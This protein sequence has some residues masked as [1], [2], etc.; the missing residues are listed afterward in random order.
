MEAVMMIYI[1][2][3]RQ[4]VFTILILVLICAILA[5]KE[6]IPV[7]A[8]SVTNRTII[9]DAGHGG[10]DPGALG[11]SGSLEKDINLNIA[12]KLQQFVEQN[13]GITIMTRTEDEML[14]GNKKEDMK[15]RKKLREENSGDIFIS[16]HLNSFPQESC[17]GSQTFYANNEESKEL[18]EKIQRN[19][20]K[21]LDENNTRIA[22]KLT[23]VYLLKNVNIPSVIVECGFLSNSEE[24]KLLMDETYQSKIAFSIYSGVMEY[25]NNEKVE[26]GS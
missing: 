10:G 7:I 18:A 20:V 26:E 11:G 22:K 1:I 19:M 4:I 14:S 16:I 17:K 13:G 21:Y 25:F 8:T 12:L 6:Y 2:R 5:V 24:E 15:I 9:I 23:D 3:K